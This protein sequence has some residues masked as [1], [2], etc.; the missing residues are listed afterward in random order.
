M[1]LIHVCCIIYFSVLSSIWKTFLHVYCFSCLCLIGH[2]GPYFSPVPRLLAVCVVLRSSD[3]TN[4]FPIQNNHQA[5]AVG[6]CWADSVIPITHLWLIEFD[7]L[8]SIISNT[9]MP[10][11]SQ[12]DFYENFSLKS[13]KAQ[14]SFEKAWLWRYRMVI[15]WVRD[16][17][18][19][20][21]SVFGWVWPI[22]WC[23]YVKELG[24]RQFLLI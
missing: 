18:T 15:T 13:V 5:A 2:V 7:F 20:T 17:P 16:C 3:K 24:F 22:W 1:A 21:Y 11:S 19:I 10:H 23:C 9:T 4:G 12:N 14:I 8:F 6:L